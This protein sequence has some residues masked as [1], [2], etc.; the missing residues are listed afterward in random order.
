[1]CVQ[2]DVET[3]TSHLSDFL[4]THDLEQAFRD[5]HMVVQTEKAGETLQQ[6]ILL[7]SG[8]LFQHTELFQFCHNLPTAVLRA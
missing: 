8:E 3:C 6:F 4:G 1:M 5:E 7:I 2:L